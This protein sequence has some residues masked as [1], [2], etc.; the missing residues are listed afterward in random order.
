[1]ILVIFNASFQVIAIIA[2]IIIIIVVFIVYVACICTCMSLASRG[3]VSVLF[4]SDNKL[5]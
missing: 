2:I 4:K 1:M 3:Q 5:S